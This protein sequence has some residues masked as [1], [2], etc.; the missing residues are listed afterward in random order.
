MKIIIYPVCLFFIFTTTILSSCGKTDTMQYDSSVLYNSGGR[1]GTTKGSVSSEN[2]SRK[3]TEKLQYMDNDEL[4]QLAL[5]YGNQGRFA[6]A[7]ALYEKILKTDK[8]FPAIHYYRGL[9]YRNMGMLEESIS[10]FR[11]AVAQN[12]DM[13]EAHYNLGYAYRRKGLYKEAIFEF[14]KTLELI[15]EKKKRQIAAVHYNLGVSFFSSGLFDD[16]I[17]EFKK[18][19]AYKPHD[20]EIHQKLGIAYSAKGWRDMAES[21]FLLFR[22]NDER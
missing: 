5:D 8:D 3:L 7:L 2:I 11:S 16:A 22:E 12:P 14:Q 21:E 19:L 4:F 1:Y 10:A 17:Q 20:K 6:E 18:V 13:P 15:P 9:L